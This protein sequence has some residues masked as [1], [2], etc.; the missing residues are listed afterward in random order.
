[1]QQWNA[2]KLI[3]LRPHRAPALPLGLLGK[4]NRMICLYLRVT[5]EVFALYP[6]WQIDPEPTFMW[7]V[8]EIEL[9]CMF[10]HFLW[11]T[12]LIHTLD[13]PVIDSGRTFAGVAEATKG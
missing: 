2:S 9:F 7:T 10:A 5:P 11:T 4:R 13:L 1:M 12:K 6:T 3:S 8:Y